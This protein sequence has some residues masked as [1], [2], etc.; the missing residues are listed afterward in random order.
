MLMQGPFGCTLGI[1]GTHTAAALER[2]LRG[3]NVSLELSRSWGGGQPR[4]C[5]ASVGGSHSTGE[6]GWCLCSAQLVLFGLRWLFFLLF[7]CKHVSISTSGCLFQF[8]SLGS[9]G[10]LGQGLKSRLVRGDFWPP[11]ASF[12][13]QYGGRRLTGSGFAMAPLAASFRSS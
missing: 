2:S 12:Q 6:L 8:H 5:T 4:I 11:R 3:Q 1:S 13:R 7:V 10:G 9:L